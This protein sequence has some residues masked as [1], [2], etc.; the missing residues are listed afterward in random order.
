MSKL[1]HHHTV[2]E[3][4]AAP[5]GD[6]S[7][8]AT[9]DEHDLAGA[10]HLEALTSAHQL[11]PTRMGSVS[12][13]RDRRHRVHRDRRPP[14]GERTDPVPRGHG[15][16]HDTGRA[17]DRPGDRISAPVGDR[18]CARVRGTP[19]RPRPRQEATANTT[20]ARHRHAGSGAD[21]QESTSPH[22]PRGWPVLEGAAAD[23]RTLFV[24]PDPSAWPRHAASSRSPA[25]WPRAPQQPA[26][27]D[28]AS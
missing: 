25:A 23:G 19:D 24:P 15:P 26:R 4:E 2:P 14:R 3:A 11:D 20:T 13:W 21:T 27:P 28:G 18:V 10:R 6:E 12:R 5:A 17:G 22:V 16:R 9:T 8:P 1:H 7:P